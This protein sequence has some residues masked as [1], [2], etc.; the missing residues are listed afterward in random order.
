MTNIKDYEVVLEN[1]VYDLKE[2][3]KVHPGGS[4]ILN[5]FGGKDATIHYYMLH[6]HEKL[7]HVLDKYKIRKY[8]NVSMYDINTSLFNDLKKTDK[9]QL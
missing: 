7:R 5:I 9:M 3:S 6:S 4:M 2:F 1:N 8:N